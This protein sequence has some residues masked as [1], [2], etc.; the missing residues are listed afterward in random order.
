MSL[1][2]KSAHLVVLVCTAAF[3]PALSTGDGGEPASATILVSGMTALD[4][5]VAVRDAVSR[6]RDGR[7]QQ[8]L[9]DFTAQE[10][11]SLREALGPSTP[12]AYLLR[13]VVRDGEIPLGSGHCAVAGSAAFTT[14]GA[15]VFVCGTSFRRLTRGARANALIH[16]MLHTLGLRENP[17]TS[18]EIARRVRARCGS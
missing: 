16:E 7:C 15:A 14:N 9:D 5:T 10:G 12:D 17:P 18:T 2:S 11:R 4:V 1:R 3:V 13:L 8:V 6:L